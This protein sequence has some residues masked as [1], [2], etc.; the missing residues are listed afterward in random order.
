MANTQIRGIKVN[1]ISYDLNISDIVSH[2]TSP[3][4]TDYVLKVDNNGNLY[5]EGG[6]PSVAPLN[7]PTGTTPTTVI[8]PASVNKL[9]INEIYC[10]GLNSDEHS[11]NYC[12][13][14][15]VELSNLTNKDI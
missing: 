2:I 5:A 14:N 6:S 3:D 13:H 8:T 12:S 9:Y 7:P 1:G 10:G 11:I 15:F 4:G